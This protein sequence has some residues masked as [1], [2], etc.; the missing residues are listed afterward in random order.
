[1]K[2]IDGTLYIYST[3]DLLLT[4]HQLSF[5]VG[6]TIRNTD[7]SR[8]KSQ[9]ISMLKKSVLEMLP[10]NENMSLFLELLAKDKPRYLR[11]NLKI[12]EKKGTEISP[13]FLN[14]AV[15]FC[16]ENNIFNASQ[17]IEI[18]R[19]KQVSALQE[20]CV[21]YNIPEITSSRKIQTINV[22]KGYRAYFTTMEALDDEVLATALLDRILYHCEVI[23]LEGNSYRMENRKNIL[24]QKEIN[25]D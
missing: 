14:A 23:K 8:D 5:E 6:A 1:M 3:R 10:G 4:T 2:E 11:D 7:H 19:H 9:S 16:L 15:K 13:E 25:M 21:T 17:L 18:A 22:Q 24:S 20:H 12:I